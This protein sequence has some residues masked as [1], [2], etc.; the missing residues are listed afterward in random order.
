MSLKDIIITGSIGT[1]PTL[2]YGQKEYISST[3]EQ[4][5]P[6]EQITGS[7]A[8]AWPNF[9]LRNVNSTDSA[10]NTTVDLAVNV[11][12]SW[13][14]YENTPVGIVSSVHDTMEEFINGEFSGSNY[15]VS[16]GSLTDEDCK[17][18][19]TVNT[20]TVT[21]DLYWY[22]SS[23]TST[24]DF[25]NFNTSPNPGEIYL[26]NY[27][28]VS[29]FI[30]L[31]AEIYLKINRT[32]VQGNNNTLSLQEL[33]NIRIP[34]SD[35]GIVEFNVLSIT[36][37][38]SYYLYFI[39][40][41]FLPGLATASADNNILDYTFYAI[42]APSFTVPGGVFANVT[43]SNY[44]IINDSLNAFNAISGLYSA[45]NTSNINLQYTASFVV[46]T[47]GSQ[48]FIVVLGDPFDPFNNNITGSLLTTTSGIPQTF[49][50]SGSF[51][52][53]ENNNYCLRFFNGDID[54]FNVSL[55]GW[56]F[57]QSIAPQSSSNLTILEPY[58]LSDFEYNDCN[59]LYGNAV[60]L[61]YDPNFMLVKYDDGS[62]I[63]SNQ[64]Q[65]LSQS[66]ELAPVKP[67]NYSARAQILPRYNGVRV[68][69]QNDNIWTSGD[70]APS[71]TPS[72]QLLSTYLAYFDWMG[73]TNYELNDKYAAHIKY[74]I[75]ENG[76]V[77]S[78]NISSSYYYNL[79]DNFETSKKV[80]IILYSDSG[81]TSNIGSAKNV[82]RAGA[83]PWG[84]IASQTGSTSHSESIMSFTNPNV[85]SPPQYSSTYTTDITTLNPGDGLQLDFDNTAILTS[86]F[87]TLNDPNDIEVNTSTNQAT[88]AVQTQFTLT[89][90]PI[91]PNPPNGNSLTFLVRLQR[92]TGFSW[93]TIAEQQYFFTHPNPINVN[94]TSPYFPINAS[95][96][97]RVVVY[98]A[99]GYFSMTTTVGTFNVLQ[100]PQSAIGIVT[101]SY[102]T[103]GSSSENILTGSQFGY[104]YQIP[105][106]Y[107]QNYPPPN[108]Y[109]DFL[110]F[111]IQS[112][113]D[114]IRFEGDE[115]QTYLITDVKQV[116]ETLYLTL[117]RNI[118]SGTN[119]DSF[120]IRRFHP[121]PNFITL[122]WNGNGYN[123]GGG[124]LIPE[125]TSDNVMKKFDS[126]IVKLKEK[127]LI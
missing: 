11:T 36:E 27:N 109:F 13:N 88:I 4:S 61:E 104:I 105:E 86:S 40:P 54:A 125:H 22:N 118:S 58:L 69:Q 2:S 106:I 80:N 5:F 30:S 29:F 123:G 82:L 95:D 7:Y 73:G 25:L 74:L 99:S 10:S 53:L 1:Y 42:S 60:G 38:P 119:L 100:N 85:P 23:I 20:T 50:L 114:Q 62:L 41:Y 93:T 121:H 126:I 107:Q 71:Q 28:A 63:P 15:T 75:D 16:D 67:Y 19:L 116:Y 64:Q 55:V 110:N 32:D 97:Y 45:N 92:N 65:I 98:N 6:I 48:Q 94:L 79:I 103:T 35:F 49:T 68:T 31:N 101:S 24:S 12:Q 102:W 84:I 91:N 3:D 8:G 72:V 44:T 112:G 51:T 33:T 39:T 59:S 14:V 17:Q 111:K 113:S 47:T 87:I 120:L 122:D 57:T 9:K 76:E 89:S 81:G 83:I 108:T 127:G 77:Y 52:T 18:F 78:P 56:I 70:V 43:A 66:A 90:I 124:F 34:T 21:Y 117:N 26:Y 96:K 115:N 46:D 37:Y